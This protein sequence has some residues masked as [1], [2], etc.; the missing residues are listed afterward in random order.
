MI[1][2]NEWLYYDINIMR[3]VKIIYIEKLPVLNLFYKRN[4]YKHI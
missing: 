1:S 4:K 3:M 2:A